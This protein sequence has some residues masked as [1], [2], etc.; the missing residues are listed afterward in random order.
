MYYHRSNN[1]N[2]KSNKRLRGTNIFVEIYII[3]AAVEKQFDNDKIFE[4]M[5]VLTVILDLVFGIEWLICTNI[6]TYVN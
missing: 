5:K 3:L 4:N 6:M 2:N 1:I